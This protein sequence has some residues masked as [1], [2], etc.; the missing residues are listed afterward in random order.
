MIE[1]HCSSIR[2]MLDADYFRMFSSRTENG[3]V[4]LKNSFARDRHRWLGIRFAQ[5][6]PA[7]DVR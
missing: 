5:T 7:R 4:R 2:T 6:V 3:F 1:L